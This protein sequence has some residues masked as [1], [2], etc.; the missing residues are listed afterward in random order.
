MILTLTSAVVMLV[1]EIYIIVS[2]ICVMGFPLLEFWPAFYSHITKAASKSSM[3]LVYGI[4]LAVTW[5]GGALFPYIGGAIADFFGLK[6]IYMLVLVLSFISIIVTLRF[7]L[8][9]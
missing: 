1:D 3:A 7:K 5:G 4:I 6:S 8:K 2:V 9:N